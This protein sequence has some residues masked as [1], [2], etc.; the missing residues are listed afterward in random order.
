MK[1]Y[2]ATFT[3]SVDRTELS[4]GE[5]LTLEV[6]YS[7]QTGA[8]P[9]FS[10]LNHQFEI[11]DKRQQSQVSLIN[12]RMSSTTTWQLTLLPKS[13]GAAVI[14]TFHFKGESSDA[15]ELT[16]LQTNNPP[17]SAIKQREPLFVEAELD[18]N[19]SYV[20]AQSLLTLRLY[21]RVSLNGLSHEDP[22]IPNAKVVKVSENQQYRKQIGDENYVVVES[23][24]ALF[25]ERSGN[26]TIPAVRFQIS[27]ADNPS[28]FDG[29]FGSR[30]KTAY[31]HSEPLT[32]KV[33][34]AQAL[35]GSK[36]WLPA[37][38]VEL[39]QGW[40]VAGLDEKPN[41]DP[42][43]ISAPR[44]AML[45]EPIT[46]S[47][48]ISADGL[49]AAQISPLQFTASEKYRL[50]P[51]Q[52]LTEDE[53]SSR[54]VTG[55]RTERMAIVP[56]QTGPLELPEI[57]LTWWDTEKEQF[58]TSTLPGESFE[59]I[60]AS[61][62]LLDS[63]SPEQTLLSEKPGSEQQAQIADSNPNHAP[64]SS[65]LIVSNAVFLLS[66]LLFALLW[67]RRTPGDQKDPEN[68]DLSAKQNLS[69]Y[70]KK[71]IQ[72]SDKKELFELRSAI[73]DWAR[74]LWHD[75]N[76]LT[77]E[78]IDRR[79]PQLELGTYFNWLDQHIYARPKETE[80]MQSEHTRTQVSELIGRLKQLQ[81]DSTNQKAE[82]GVKLQ[83]LYP[84]ATR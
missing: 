44:Q 9:N 39:L 58:R 23:R 40:K 15:I 71:I 84:L 59:I 35:K 24:Y 72:V 29:F 34:P 66:T 36:R 50:Y 25:P 62:T 1:G 10:D 17:G 18:Q 79:A 80:E 32:L 30:G 51:D 61:T 48:T 19:S 64:L 75:P 11:L 63:T 60:P 45:G 49:S 56:T 55:K 83:A 14:P 70:F 43:I 13:T 4:S 5:T 78:Q 28:R 16:I 65:W 82:K 26:I 47:V 8:E 69:Y 21:T 37:R 33:K 54:G 46:R 68:L 57:Q 74:I 31:L 20:Q 81:D 41:N 67:F 53:V 77:L 3:S 76:I 52:A 42:A 12:G 38:Q 73:L 22:E 27:I 2:T 7:G 6:V